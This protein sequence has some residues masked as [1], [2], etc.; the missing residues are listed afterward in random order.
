MKTRN[1]AIV[2]LAAAGLSTAT[3]AEPYRDYSPKA[4]LWE[5]NRVDVDP[6]H[7]DDYLTGLKA[8]W[9]PG[10]EVQKANGI[11][12]D[13]Q[14]LVG[15]GYTKGEGNVLLMVHYTSAAMLEANRTRDLKVM[16]ESLARVSKQQSQM[17]I[18]G[19]EKYRTFVGTEHYTTVKFTK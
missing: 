15:T 12:D 3:L 14:M 5:I 1:A 17:A 11:I 7:I 9:R 2:A 6:N 10:L 13:Y 4:G 16:R 8:E 18:E 19:F